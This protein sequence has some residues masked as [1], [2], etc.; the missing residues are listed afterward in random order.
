MTYMGDDENREI[1]IKKWLSAKERSEFL[2][3]EQSFGG[4]EPTGEEISTYTIAHSI[5]TSQ[6]ANMFNDF[7]NLGGKGYQEGLEFGRYFQSAHR[8][9][10]QCFVGYLMGALMGLAEMDS[11]WTDA[12]NQDSHAMLLKLKQLVEDGEIAASFRHI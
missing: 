4:H 6:L 5:T 12:R 3:E 10:Q 1:Q 9:I 11:K 8:T 2:G 7:L